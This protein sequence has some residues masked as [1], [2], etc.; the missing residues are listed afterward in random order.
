M[1]DWICCIAESKGSPFL[2]LQFSI[3]DNISSLHDDHECGLYLCST[4]P[5][6]FT[7][8][9]AFQVTRLH[10][11]I[12]A[13]SHTLE[14]VTTIAGCHLLIG[15][16]NSHTHNA[17]KT[18]TSSRVGLRILLKDTSHRHAGT[19]QHRPSD[20]WYNYSST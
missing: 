18:S 7:T 20:H 1:W 17:T 14:A 2:L 10:S 8:Q 11:P 4:L 15:K 16:D 3:T 9:S 12:H 19:G 6:I 13:H 5:V